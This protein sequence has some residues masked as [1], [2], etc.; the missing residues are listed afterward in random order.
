MNT[1]QKSDLK[2]EKTITEKKSLSIKNRLIISFLIILLVPTLMVGFMSFTNSKDEIKKKILLSSEENVKL[3]NKFLNSKIEPKLF[4]T[5]YFTEVLNRKSYSEKEL[6]NTLNKFQQYKYLHEESVSVYVGTE[7]GEMLL[8]PKQELPEGFDPRQRPWYQDAI[9]SNGKP[10]IT[11]PYVDA[12]TGDL[13]V[14]VAQVVNDGSGVFG[15]DISLNELKEITDGIKIGDRGYP[16]ILGTD[17]SYIVHPSEKPGDKAEGDWVSKVFG[18]EKGHISYQFNGIDKE[19]D[20]YTNEL[21]GWKIIGSMDLT[22]IDEAAQPILTATLA[23]ISIFVIVG[24]ILSYFI[25]QSISRPIREL[26]VVTDLVA[27][28]DLTKLYLIKRN[29]E[30]GKLGTSFNNMIFAL[31]DLI[32]QVGEKS[33]Q[34]ASSSEQLNASSE[35]NNHATEQVAN[36]IQEVASG[37]ENQR[38]MVHQSTEVVTEMSESIDKIMEN[39]QQVAETAAVA[40][41]VVTEGEQSIKKSIEQMKNINETVA[42]LGQV[43]HT[44]GTRSNEISQIVNVITEIANQTN[45]LALNAAIEAARAGEHGKG[46]AVVADEVRKLAEQSAKSTESIRHLIASIQADTN[47]AVVS[48]EK[49]SDEVEKGIQIVDHAGTSFRKIQTFVDN[50]SHQIHEVSASMEEMGH[51]AKQIVEFVSRIEEITAG[52]NAESQEVSAA[53]EEQ[54]ASMQEIA[55]SAASLS[56]M[57]EELQESVRKFKI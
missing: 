38:N 20:F 16:A 17:G 6:Q 35:Q 2:E 4:D 44:L 12:A 28:G 40:H 39:A 7:T 49:G 3:L 34:L 1:R 30:V 51:G 26:R 18:G 43:I 5:A 42:D 54:L 48:M 45:L 33:D 47:Q 23:V 50:V 31:K 11:N 52:V 14:T 9:S 46:F 36:A 57:A 37:T 29:D 55:A 24:A 25:I 53:T 15:I 19:M 10:I 13:L 21:T 22:E 27:N 41:E 8:F 32:H 56:Y